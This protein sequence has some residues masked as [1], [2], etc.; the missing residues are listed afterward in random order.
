MLTLRA[1]VDSGVHADVLSDGLFIS[2]VVSAELHCGLIFAVHRYPQIAFKLLVIQSWV[3]NLHPYAEVTRCAEA[4]C[5][6]CC[7]KRH[8]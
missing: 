2:C 5:C 6:C 4:V 1:A 8:Y 7:L 3:H